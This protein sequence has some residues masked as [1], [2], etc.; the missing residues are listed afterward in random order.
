MLEMRLGFG[1][2]YLICLS[3]FRV[4]HKICVRFGVMT[5]VSI[6]FTLD[7]LKGMSCDIVTSS[8]EKSG[9]KLLFYS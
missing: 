3:R 6:A 2:A 4:I 8:S 1:L 7:I 5:L 9:V